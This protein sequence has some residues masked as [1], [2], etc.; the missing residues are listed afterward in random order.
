[1]CLPEAIPVQEPRPDFVPV[2][3][4]ELELELE[5]LLEPGL[6]PEKG[7]RAGVHRK[8]VRMSYT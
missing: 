7:P 1:M 5:L 6:Q 3:E 8:Y 4:L 2:P